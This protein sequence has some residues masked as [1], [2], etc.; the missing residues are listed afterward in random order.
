MQH[1][2][3]FPDSPSPRRQPSQSESK[4]RSST[5]LRKAAGACIPSALFSIATVWLIIDIWMRT[6]SK[7]MTPETDV[8]D[9]TTGIP[10]RR[11]CRC[12]CRNESRQ[13]ARSPKSCA[14][15]SVPSATARTPPRRPCSPRWTRSTRPSR[16]ASTISPLSGFARRWSVCSARFPGCAAR[17]PASAP[18]AS[19]IPPPSPCTS[20]RCSSPPLPVCSSPSRPSWDSISCATSSRPASTTFEEE[21]ESLFRNAPYEYLKDAD[22]GQEETYAA[23]PNWVAGVEGAVQG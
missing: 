13:P 9:R 1:S 4:K 19:V 23:L 12:L 11:L 18:P 3:S 7:K 21:A 15:P 2:C 5:F 16:P 17:S 22:V 20:A 6:N 10:R 8:Q 14:P